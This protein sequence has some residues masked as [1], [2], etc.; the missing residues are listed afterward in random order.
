MPGLIMGVFENWTSV[1]KDGNGLLWN[2]CWPTVGPFHKL[3]GGHSKVAPRNPSS[4]LQE[5]RLSSQL[6]PIGVDVQPLV[7][8]LNGHLSGFP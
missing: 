4:P 8:T 3:N 6:V 1:P 2:F 5:E 7:E